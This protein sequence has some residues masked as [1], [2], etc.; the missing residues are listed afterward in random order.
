MFYS[1]NIRKELRMIF[2]NIARTLEAAVR[3]IDKVIKF[4]SYFTDINNMKFI[5]EVF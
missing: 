2:D 1:S 4:T 5:N 3:F